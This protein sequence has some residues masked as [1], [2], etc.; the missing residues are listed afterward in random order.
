VL[1]SI[2]S[3]IGSS[4]LKGQFPTNIPIP[5]NMFESISMLER[6]AQNMGF[7]PL[8]L[9]KAGN[10]LDPVEQI[11]YTTSFLIATINMQIRMEKPFNPVLGETF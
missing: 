5:L 2:L 9:E 4:L 7:A 11:K 6:I 1:S 10:C 3:K 8:F